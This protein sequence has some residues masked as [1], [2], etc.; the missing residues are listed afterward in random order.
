[1][2][3]QTDNGGLALKADI[4]IGADASTWNT[5]LSQ[6]SRT[7]AEVILCTYSLPN[8]PSVRQ[9]LD[10]RSRNI[11]LIVN[12]RFAAQANALKRAYPELTLYL[13]PRTHAKMALI[14]PA[15]VWLSSENIG[16]SGWYENTVGIRSAAAYDYLRASV[17]RMLA[18]NGLR[19]E[20]SG[21]YV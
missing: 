15:T 21:A 18:R 13:I 1:M 4:K 19:D 14:A 16:T 10:R 2:A 12:A 5:R 8:I 3:F 11:T 7:D 6:L 9:I 17:F 20:R